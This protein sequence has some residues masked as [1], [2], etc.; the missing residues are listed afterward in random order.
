MR[1]FVTTFVGAIALTAGTLGCAKS[2]VPVYQ[3]TAD[4][5]TTRVVVPTA[6]E[7][8]PS[9]PPSQDATTAPP[10]ASEPSWRG[11]FCERDEDCG[12]DDP[13][14]PKRCGERVDSVPVC[15]E[16]AP[17]PGSC[18]CIEG[19]CT[20]RRSRLS[21]GDSPFPACLHDE[22]CAIDI[23]TG[24]CHAHGTHQVGPIR[25]QGP[26]CFCKPSMGQCALQWAEP[27]PCE[28]WRDCSWVREPRLRPVPSKQVPRPVPREVR[29]CKDGEIDS[30][31]AP[32]KTCRIVGWKC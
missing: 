16:S 21:S 3:A 24:T 29:P 6:P 15:N 20:L 1:R 32:D 17:A 18:T 10:A 8:A 30:V 19:M 7:E 27:V 22:D 31:C 2:E 14:F 11:H 25:Q 9:P 28:T 4:E 13:C 5:S 12:W 26:F 23:G